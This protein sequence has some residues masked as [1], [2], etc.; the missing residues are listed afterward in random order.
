MKIIR[1]FIEGLKGLNFFSVLEIIGFMGFIVILI[2][3]DIQCFKGVSLGDIIKDPLSRT[4]A[5]LFIVGVIG[6]FLSNWVEDTEWS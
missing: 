5:I 1:S 3:C 4:M 6:F 2:Y